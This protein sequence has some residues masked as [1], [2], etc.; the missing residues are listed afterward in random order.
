MVIFNEVIKEMVYVYDFI[1]I[2]NLLCD[3]LW[4]VCMNVCDIYVVRGVMDL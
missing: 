3:W 1:L 4:R 2:D